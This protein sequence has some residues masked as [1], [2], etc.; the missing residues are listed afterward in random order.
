MVLCRILFSPL[1]FLNRN[2]S[3]YGL[4][5]L[6]GEAKI[7]NMANQDMDNMNHAQ[8]VLARKLTESDPTLDLFGSGRK[9]L[10]V[11]SQDF[12]NYMKF[13]CNLSGKGIG[14]DNIMEKTG[15]FMEEAG[16]LEAF[17]T[18]WAGLWLKKWKKRVKLI[19]GNQSPN[20][21]N[22]GKELISKAEPLW[23]ELGCRQE[24]IEILASTLIRNGEICGTEILATHLL[25]RELGKKSNQGVHKINQL[26]EVLNDTLRRARDVAQTTGPFIFIKIEKGYYEHQA[27][28]EISRL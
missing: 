5:Q 14:I 24:L 17:S 1:Y 10:Q 20:S 22:L 16:E 4:N 18:V 11:A 25:K 9:I 12:T 15:Q 2:I 28:Q 27:P 19:F 6:Y 7:M 13:T 8:S 21:S 23:K 26:L 3:E